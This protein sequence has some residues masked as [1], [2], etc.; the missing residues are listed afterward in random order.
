M[1]KG[2]SIPHRM[3]LDH[4]DL[5]RF[6]VDVF[7]FNGLNPADAA[8]AA[9]ALVEASLRGVD[10]HG[11]ARVPMYC[12]RL[13]KGVANPT[14]AIRVT[15]VAPAVSL[16]DG[17][18]GLGLVV[19]PRGM[20]EAIA[21]AKECGIGMAGVRRSGHY[22]MGA[23]YLLQ[24]VEAGCIGMAFTNASPAMPVWGG[25]SKFLGTSPFAVGA[26]AGEAV[27]FLLDMACSVVARGKLKFAA[28][29]GEAI[30]E[31]LALDKD[32]RPTTDGG[33]AFEGVVLPFGGVKGAGLSMLME[34]LSG[35]LTGAAFGG[36]VKNPFTGLDGP[37]GTGHCFI[38]LKADLFMPLGDFEARMQTFIGR[39]KNQPLAEGFEDILVP[40]EPGHRSFLNRSEQGIP[41]TMDVVDALRAEAS[42]AGI[43]F[44]DPTT[45]L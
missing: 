44:P 18:D 7:T 43:R 19:G 11:I 4:R 30:A 35:V 3:A 23:L 1:G 26:P 29:R 36:D 5:R 22:G 16:L 33:K 9:N 27:P 8:I 41:V 12:E 37:Q 20:A 42:L 15:R 13:R 34:I 10:S 14:P 40:G 2:H 21:I 17:D 45:A 38:A 28:Q 25:R 24:A 31:G 32:G 6:V 39:I